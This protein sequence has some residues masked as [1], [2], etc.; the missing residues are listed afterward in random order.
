[1]RKLSHREPKLTWAKLTPSRCHTLSSQVH[2][3]NF[4]TRVC[5]VKDAAW[6]CVKEACAWHWAQT[7]MEHL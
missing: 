5:F 2:I 6:M 4:Y 3:P 1:M 7:G